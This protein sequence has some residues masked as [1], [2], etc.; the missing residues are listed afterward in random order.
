MEKVLG[1]GNALV[2]ILVKLP[3]D[4]LLE[5]F[6]LPKGSMQH[7]DLATSKKILISVESLIEAQAAGGSA[8]NT[9][10]GLANLGVECGYIGK[11]GCDDLGAFFKE[12][13]ERNSITPFLLDSET[14]TGR[15]AALIS[16][17]QERTMATYLGA[18]IEMTAN[19]LKN[20]FFIGYKYFHLEGYLTQNHE[21]I[22]KAVELAK[23]NRLIIS[24]DLSAYN[25]VEANFDFLHKL[26]E[27]YIDIVFANED[28]AKAFT[29][30]EDPKEMALKIAEKCK[31]AVVKTGSKGS[32]ICSDGQ[33]TEISAIRATAVDTTGAGDLYASGFIFGL[34]QGLPLMDCGKIASITAGHVVEVLGPKMEDTIWESIRSKIKSL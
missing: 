23:E 21:L 5:K 26:T 17:D 2:D 29:K 15:V 32:V 34:L 4:E 31:I 7:V 14:G 12:D 25:V 6:S 16:S 33:L 13:L 1:L 24:L 30:L 18:A 3:T 22:Q 8:A 28:E 20:D 9:I 19:D 10:N 11:I 27:D